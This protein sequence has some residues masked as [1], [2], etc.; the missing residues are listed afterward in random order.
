MIL[1]KLP[2]TAPA[3][4]LSMPSR[5][6]VELDTGLDVKVP[7]G[8]RMRFDLVRALSDQGLVLVPG[9]PVKEGRIKLTVL[10]AGRNI[11]NLREG[12]PLATPW[13]E[14]EVKLEWA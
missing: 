1:T 8:Y 5:Y 13:L 12:D 11:V 2:A 6:M 4:Q 7:A 10:N 14:R 9:E 3:T